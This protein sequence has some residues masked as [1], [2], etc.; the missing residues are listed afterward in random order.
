MGSEIML[1]PSLKFTLSLSKGS[2]WQDL[3]LEMTKFLLWCTFTRSIK[4]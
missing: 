2:E 1:D 4:M 3:E